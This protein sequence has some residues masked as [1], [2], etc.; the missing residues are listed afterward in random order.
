MSIL[1]QIIRRFQQPAPVVADTYPP[2]ITAA[3]AEEVRQRRA[4]EVARDAYRSELRMRGMTDSQL[5]ALVEFY[6][7]IIRAEAGLQT[8]AKPSRA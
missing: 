1:S 5:V 3:I 8:K 7:R 6:K 4:A 2:E